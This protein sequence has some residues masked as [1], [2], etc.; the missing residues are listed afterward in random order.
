MVGREKK[1]TM[2]STHHTRAKQRGKSATYFPFKQGYLDIATLRIGLEGIHMSVDGKHV[3]SF[4]YRA[5]M[6]SL[7]NHEINVI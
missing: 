7:V 5:V 4:A 6:F 1:S 3:T 2:N